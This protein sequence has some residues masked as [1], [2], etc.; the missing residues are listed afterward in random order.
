MLKDEILV[1]MPPDDRLIRDLLIYERTEKY[2]R[3]NISITQQES[4]NAS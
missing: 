4:I 3:Q 2:I 1:V